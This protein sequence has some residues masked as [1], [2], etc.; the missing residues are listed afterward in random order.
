MEETMTQ[1][2]GVKAW[3]P[4]SLLPAAVADKISAHAEARDRVGKLQAQLGNATRIEL[5]QAKQRDVTAAADAVEAGRPAPKTSHGAKV[6]TKMQGLEQQ[7]AAAQLV[8]QRCLSRLN[9]AVAEHA[10][11]I[12]HEAEKRMARAKAAY[13]EALDSLAT[14]V[15]ELREAVA[16]RSWSADPSTSF[17]VRGVSVPIERHA[18]SE[19]S[20]DAVLDAMRR[21]LEPR[22][23]PTLPSPFPAPMPEAEPM[24]GVLSGT[25][26]ELATGFSAE[27]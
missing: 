15:E 26:A 24:P 4:P 10:T 22:R 23:S 27:E 21:A 12:S 9:G 8:Q 18:D 16:L 19:P 14:V 25:A 13:A 5:P 20:V 3:P 11:Q 1:T 6:L 2:F 7:I 17:K